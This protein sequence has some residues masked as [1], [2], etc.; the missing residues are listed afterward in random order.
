MWLSQKRYKGCKAVWIWGGNANNGANCGL[1][2]ANSNNAWTNANSN[3][4]AR[5][6]FKGILIRVLVLRHGK[7]LGNLAPRT[8][9]RMYS[10]LSRNNT[11]L[12]R[13]GVSTPDCGISKP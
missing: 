12:A 9:M 5:H 3:I 4:S 6:T 7:A 1:A 11:N 10:P 2:Y 8:R 13:V